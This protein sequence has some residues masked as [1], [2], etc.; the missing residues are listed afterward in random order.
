[1]VAMGLVGQKGEF[2]LEGSGIIRR[3]GPDVDDF[4]CGDQV[5]LMNSGLL[6]TR[7]IVPRKS[8][9]KLP[10]DLTMKDAATMLSVYVTAIY[11]LLHAGGL[12]KGQV[13]SMHRY[14]CFLPY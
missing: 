6:A 12:T 3:V 8:C 14:P 1:M 9:L 2:G 7:V 4:Q 13:C 11:S 5:A 10:E